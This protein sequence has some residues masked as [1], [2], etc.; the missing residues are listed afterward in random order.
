MKNNF[1][2]SLLV[3]LLIAVFGQA[4]PAFDFRHLVLVVIAAMALPLT[5]SAAAAPVGNTL[6]D[7]TLA[8]MAVTVLLVVITS[9]LG[10]R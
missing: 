7:A 9:A 1:D 10:H 3:P 5:V 4:I 8:V 2:L 6:R